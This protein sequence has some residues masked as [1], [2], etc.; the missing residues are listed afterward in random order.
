MDYANLMSLTSTRYL[1]TFIA[2]SPSKWGSLS[3][4]SFLL[5]SYL[6]QFLMLIRLLGIIDAWIFRLK[7]WRSIWKEK[8]KPAIETRIKGYRPQNFTCLVHSTLVPHFHPFLSI[9]G[10]PPP[11]IIPSSAS[12]STQPS[13]LPVSHATVSV[14]ADNT[15][16]TAQVADGIGG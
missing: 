9:S 2:D 5:S 13:S 10:L 1:C 14:A 8:W 4:N 6:R 12:A 15:L 3:P 7:R 11:N 16:T